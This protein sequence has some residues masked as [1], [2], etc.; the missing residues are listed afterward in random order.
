MTEAILRTEGLTK[1]F[2]GLVAVSDVSLDLHVGEVHV[3][4]G[5]DVAE[6]VVITRIVRLR[7]E[8]L[9]QHLGGLVDLFEIDIDAA[10]QI[11]DA[12]DGE[13]VQLDVLSVTC[14]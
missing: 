1:R 10:E 7:L 9:L 13:F 6:V 5:P 14:P 8:Q 11:A 4:I 12:F 2:G 3:V